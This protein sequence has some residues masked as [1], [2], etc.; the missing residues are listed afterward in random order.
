MVPRRGIEPRFPTYQIGVLNRPTHRVLVQ[1]QGIEPCRPLWKSGMQPKHLQCM[2]SVA[3]V[4][5]AF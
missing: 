3:G 1:S 2:E 4:E 5:P